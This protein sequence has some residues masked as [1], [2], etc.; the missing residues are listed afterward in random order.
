MV[1]SD[2]LTGKKNVSEVQSVISVT[3]FVEREA[4]TDHIATP[5]EMVRF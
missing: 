5:V 3:D 1:L 4:R 2:I